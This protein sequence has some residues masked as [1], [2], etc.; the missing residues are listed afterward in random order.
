YD[1]MVMAR[2]GLQR[3][4]LKPEHIQVLPA[5]EF[6]PA[7]GQGILGV[8]ARC[9]DRAVL[10]VLESFD[11]PAARAE[12]EAERAFLR[13][14]GAGCHTPV[15]GFAQVHDSVLAIGGL[16]AGVE[17]G[18]VTRGGGLGAPG[19]GAAGGGRLA[20]DP[21]ARGA[22]ALLEPEGA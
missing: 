7:V 8:E 15:A 21:L 11:D 12:A 5:D 16:V 10:K 18:G 6:L 3:L 13:R 14:L 19:E 22:R 1:A 17:G 9:T 4:G 20:D 2:A